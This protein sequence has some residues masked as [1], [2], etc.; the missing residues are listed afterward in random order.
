M[1]NQITFTREQ[2]YE[3]V[4]QHPLLQ[5]AQRYAMSDVGLAKLCAR[6]DIPTPPR[7]YW[8]KIQAGTKPSRTRLPPSGDTSLI[9]LTVLTPDEEAEREQQERANAVADEKKVENRIS[10]GDRLAS[11][12]ALV[13]AARTALDS[14]KP[15]EFDMLDAPDKCLQI[16]VSRA[17]LART[18]RITDALLKAC[19]ARGWETSV[20]NGKTLVQVDAVPIGLSVEELLETV[21]LPAKPSVETSYAFNYKR[22]P[23]TTKKPSGR[24]LISLQEQQY[25]WRQSLRR[26][27]RDSERTPLE[28]QLNDVIIGMLKMAAAVAADNARKER[29]AKAEEE[30]ERQRKAIAEEQRQLRAQLAEEKNRV[31]KLRDQARRWRESENL[32]RL[33]AEVQRRGIVPDLDSSSTLAEWT[34]W[35][36]GQADRLDPFTP[37]QA[38]FSTTSS[39]SRACATRSGAT[40]DP[41]KHAR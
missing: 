30:R 28:E 41:G 11:P 18:L 3:L 29:E 20:V 21:E 36:L 2:L 32:R 24:L 10:V 12:C 4:W 19:Q 40:D 26:N 22:K 9:H 15:S 35:A 17:Q 39:A 23:E 25:L 6:H 1:S 31:Q 14:A 7:G 8:A 33:V 38:R 34:Q 13:Q 27:W 16:S 5:L 37:V